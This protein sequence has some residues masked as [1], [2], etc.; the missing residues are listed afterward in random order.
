VALK[1]VAAAATV[2]VV[3]VLLASSG[4]ASTTQPPTASFTYSPA[5]P[6]VGQR[7]AFTSTSSDP[8]GTIVKQAWD[9]DNDGH[10]QDASG[11]TA[12]RSFPAVGT[13]TVRLYVLDN[14][15]A[16]SIASRT[17][18][19]SI[20]IAAAGDIAC[21]PAS[22]SYNGGA[23]TSTQCR[24][25]YTSDLLVNAGVT[26]VLTLGDN[27]YEDGAYEKFLASY[28]PSWGR[29][30]AM[31]YP[32]PGNHEYQT[33][34]AAGYFR[35]F[36]AAAGDPSKGYYS[37]DIGT[38]HLVALNS[39]CGDIGGCGPGSPQEQWLRADLAVNSEACTLAYWHH[40]LFSSGAYRPGISSVKPLFQALYDYNADVLFVGHDHN[41]ERF[42]PQ[43]PNGAPDTARGLR[44]FI[45][46]TG[47]KSLYGQGAAIAN[48]E[49]RNSDTYG[50]LKL[51]LTST[52][53]EWQFVPEA[54]RTFTD[55]GSSEC[56]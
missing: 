49:V 16:S 52:G 43:D 51:R 29:V 46:G 8:D 19:V 55:S 7:I 23:G 20:V 54:G 32:A 17:V 5:S 34:A 50:V 41:Y 4:S 48:S 36:G 26:A 18:Q 9:L 53:Y 45:V 33:P 6:T 37:Y 3:A 12:S 15:G 27:Q 10:F 25:R 28:E 40:P 24:Q 38:W 35:Y 2:S 22:P 30:K 31:T 47:G 39:N 11:S 21:D 42:A 13:Y 44:Q 1:G 14:S 56:H